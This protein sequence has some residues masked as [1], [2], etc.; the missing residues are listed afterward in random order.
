VT[1]VAWLLG[2]RTSFIELRVREYQ[3]DQNTFGILFTLAI[4]ATVVLIGWAEYNRH[5]FGGP[6]RRLPADNV[7]P[8]E[9]AT[10]L[11]SSPEIARHLAHAKSITLTMGENARP[12]GVHSHTPMSGL[13]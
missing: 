3:F 12:S 1:V 5:K 11:G 9:I 7:G 6:D 4:V 8:D 13:L 2:V 10:S